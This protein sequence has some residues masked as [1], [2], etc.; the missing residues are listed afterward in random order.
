MS[1]P[2]YLQSLHDRVLIYDGAMGT[3]IDDFDLT[4]ADYG[5]ERTFGC[6]DYLVIT[7]PDVIGQIHRNFMEAG[8]DVLETCT[9]QATRLRLEEW[10]LGERVAEVNI[11]AARLAR[12]VADEFY[13]KD[14]RPRYVAGSIGPTGKLPSSNDPALSD[15]TFDELSDIFRQQAMALIEGGVDVL[16]V[17]TSV[18]VLE[19]KAALDGIRRAK[20]DMHRPDVAVQ[21]Q[22]F[23]DMSGRMLL[24]TDIP[25]Y[26][27]TMEAMPVDVLGLNCSTGPEHM[28]EAI[29]YLTA[30]SRKPI[31]CIP[32]AGLP[33]E[34]DGATVYPMEPEP[35][36]RTLGEF[37][38]Q[39]GVNIVGGCCG[40]RP[41]H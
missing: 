15:I 36:A 5:G 20:H 32:N 33:I 29:Q 10:G 21:A 9:F 7:R 12:S 2:T 28:R 18:D 23:L 31:S 11:A 17:E 22:I 30:H 26:I 8:S 1:R 40:T 39:Y 4:P 38:T 13:A 41:S 19:V 16:L 24:G 6:R 35:F 3:S 37:V 25:A 34:V 14:G 27:A